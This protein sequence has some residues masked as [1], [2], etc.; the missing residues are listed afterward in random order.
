MFFTVS[1]AIPPPP[2]DPKWFRYGTV[3]PPA[4][5]LDNRLHVVDT[6]APRPAAH[7]LE[8]GPQ[9]RVV[10]QIGIGREIGARRARREQARALLDADVA[11]AVADDIDRSLQAVAIHD[12]LDQ[13]AVLHFADGAAGQRLRADVTDARAGGDAGEAG[14]RD[15]GDVL[16][17]RQ[18]AERGGDLVDLLHARAHRAAA[19]EYHDVACL[20]RPR[21]AALDGGDRVALAGK[22]PR[23]PYLYID[24]VSAHHAGI[25]GG[26]LD[27]R[28]LRRQ[29]A[30]RER[31]GTGE[32]ARAR[33]LGIHDHVVGSHA[34]HGLEPLAQ[35]A[36]ATRRL[37]PVEDGAEPPA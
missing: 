37:P 25:D 6:A 4:D 36:P 21:P 33:Q 30:P 13:V 8:R 20:Q 9:P 22:D 34:V 28:A 24:T 27:D 29:V 19:D 12:D 5:R 7:L 2:S 16:A 1:V 23:R 11:I 18:M 17:P 15:D 32:P 26:A 10:G 31:H 35:R 3:L 14:V